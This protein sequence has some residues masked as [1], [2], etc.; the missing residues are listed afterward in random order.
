[1]H[2]FGNF[3][4]LR[5]TVLGLELIGN[6]AAL[7]FE[8]PAHLIEPNQ[9][10]A[11]AVNILE[12]RKDSAPDWLLILKGF[13]PFR[14]LRTLP[15]IVDAPEPRSMRKAHSA[16]APFHILG[17]DIVGNKNKM[18]VPADEVIFLGAKLRRYQRQDGRSVGR[19]DGH[20]SLTRLKLC[21]EREIK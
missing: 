2:L 7:G 20:P 10:E 9:C 14:R 15:F 4:F 11:V 18:C 16:L 21:I 6:F 19:S 1:L 8:F 17:S 13:S 12:F 5:G 3:N